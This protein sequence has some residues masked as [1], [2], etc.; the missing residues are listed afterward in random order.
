M[1]LQPPCNYCGLKFN[2]HNIQ[3]IEFCFKIMARQ[4]ENIKK[5]SET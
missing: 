2:R 5:E 4:L 1:N 3:E